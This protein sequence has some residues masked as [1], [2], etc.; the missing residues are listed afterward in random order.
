MIVS[1]LI[2]SS[3]HTVISMSCLTSHNYKQRPDGTCCKTIKCSENQG[4]KLCSNVYPPGGNDSCYDCPPGT[5]NDLPTDTSEI[6]YTFEEQCKKFDCECLPEAE[7]LN[8]DECHRTEEK[9]CVCRRQDLRYGD[10]P[11]AC[12]GPVNDSKKLKE[13]RRP[14]YE[15]KNTAAGDVAE[16][17]QGYFKNKSDDSICIPHTKCPKGYSVIF[18]GSTTRDRQCQ[19]VTTTVTPLA[20]TVVQPALPSTMVLSVTSLPISRK[21]QSSEQGDLQKTPKNGTNLRSGMQIAPEVD[22]TSTHQP[23]DQ[24]TEL[25]GDGQRNIHLAIGLGI[26][27]LFLV[28]VFVIIYWRCIKKKKNKNKDLEQVCT[29]MIPMQECGNLQN[30]GTVPAT[31]GEIKDPGENN[32]L[33]PVCNGSQIDNSSGKDDESLETDD[34]GQYTKLHIHPSLPSSEVS[35]NIPYK[36]VEGYVLT[37][38][39]STEEIQIVEENP[40][41]IGKGKLETQQCDLTNVTSRAMSSMPSMRSFG[42]SSGNQLFLPPALHTNLQIS[43]FD[44]NSVPLHSLGSLK[45]NGTYS[46]FSS[47]SFDMENRKKYAPL[48]DSDY[49]TGSSRRNDTDNSVSLSSDNRYQELSVDSLED[50]R[51]LSTDTQSSTKTGKS[52]AVVSPF[53]RN[54]MKTVDE[55]ETCSKSP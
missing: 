21:D 55:E 26:G 41:E 11:E 3:L 36:E 48:E 27:L 8:R 29:D 1:L 44:S 9:K 51:Q 4:Y 45:S 35:K 17:D 38:P 23:Q 16:C 46:S 39:I 22:G 47:T 28:L 49:G 19:L 25:I 52:V 30:S 32:L 5:F 54:E 43:S 13:I 24:M 12:K 6:L 7:L 53:R 31:L 14:G 42:L 18:N 50:P 20:T 10:N 2:L 33:L 37:G 34:V 15:L 40:K